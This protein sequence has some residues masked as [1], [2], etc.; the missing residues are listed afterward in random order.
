MPLIE[1]IPIREYQPNDPYHH[2]AD[3]EPIQDLS[4][5]I[6]L[7]NFQVENDRKILTDSIGTQGTLAARLAVSLN[8]DGTLKT[9]AIDNALHS[10]AQHL[11]SGGYVRM[12]D[13]ERSKLSTIASG[14]TNLTVTI[15]TI[16]TIPE[17]TSGTVTFKPSDSVTWRVSGANVYADVT[18]PVTARHQHFYN[19]PPVHVNTSTPD[20]KNYYTTSVFTAYKQDSLR[21]FI[22]GVRIAKTGYPVVWVPRYNGTTLTWFQTSFLEDTASAVSGVITS[23]KF[24]LNT[25]ITS[26]DKIY[27]DFEI[28]LV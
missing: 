1:N 20:Y 15:E 28:A 8:N 11:D 7:I 23:G 16:S 18:F 4:A 17:Y 25:A 27:I 9:V 3:N 24:V 26:A 12:T 6:S 13:T 22:N 10:I 2:V 21:V 14:A 19:I 5:Q